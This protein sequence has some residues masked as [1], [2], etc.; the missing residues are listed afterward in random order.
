MLFQRDC[1]SRWLLT[2]ALAV[3]ASLC[4][5]TGTKAQDTVT[6]AFEGRITNSQTGAPIVGASIQ[7]INQA[8]GVPIAKRTDSDGRFYQGLLQPGTYTIRASAP[9]FKT[10]E[11]ERR[12]L[13]T[14][15]NRV[16]P[17]PVTLEPEGTVTTTTTTTT[18]TDPTTTTTTTTTPTTTTTTTTPQGGDQGQQEQ[19]I[20][21][22]I[23]QTDARRGGAFTEREVST[24]PLGAT[25]LVRSFDELALLLPGV[26]LPPLTSG[27]AGPGVGPGVGSPGQFAVNGLRSRA[28]NFTVDGSDN[29]DEDIG[30]RRQGFF[31]LI[32]QPV[33]SIREFQVITLLAPA[34]FGR[35]IGAQVNAISKSGGNEMHGTLYGFFNSSDLNARN[36]FDNTGGQSLV[37]ISVGPRRVSVNCTTALLTDC[38][39]A[40]TL[41]NTGD[42]DSLTLA[43]GGF[44][45]GGPLDVIRG[46]GK[47]RRMFYFVSA[48]GQLMNANKEMSFAVPTVA[49]RGAFNTGLTG[50]SFDPLTGTPV[51]FG[52]EF[53]TTVTGDAIFSFFPFPNNP[54]GIYGQN[55]FTQVI[56]ASA[57][58]KVVSG[59]FDANFD[60]LGRNHNFT[61]RYNLTDDWR[62]IPAVGGALFSR[63]RPRVRTQNFSTFLNTELSGATSTTPVFNQLRLSYGRTRLIFDE[64][65]DTDYLRPTRRRFDDPAQG[66]FL[67]NRPLL[68]NATLPGD[69][70]AT[71]FTFGTGE[72]ETAETDIFGTRIGPIGQLI[73]AGFSPVGVDVFNFPQRRVNNTYQLADTVSMRFGNHSL[74]FGADIRRTELN[75]DLPRNSRPLLTFNGAPR[76][77]A[78]PAPGGGFNF[79]FAANV[80][81]TPRPFISPQD[82]AAAGAPSGVFQSIVRAGRDAALSLRY[83]QLDF[84]VQDEWRIRPNFSLSY[85][86]RYEYNTVPYDTQDRIEST[87]GAALTPNAAVGGLSTFINGRTDIYDPDRN[88]FAPRVGFAWSPDWFGRDKTTVI[89]AGYGLFYDQILGA[90]VSQSRNVFPTFS[91]INF[92]G[93]CCNL[94]GTG[95]DEGFNIFNPLETFYFNGTQFVPIIQ[96]GTVNTLNPQLPFNTFTTTTFNNFPQFFGT[97]FGAT[98]PTRQLEMPMAHHYSATFEQQLSSSMVFSAAYVGTLG[99]NL[100]RFTTPN[101]GPNYLIVPLSYNAFA[102]SFGGGT[103]SGF[104]IDPGSLT[105]AATFVNGR[106][107]ANNIGPISQ[108]ET[109]AESRYDALQLQLRGRFS[110]RMQY[111]VAYTF[112][113]SKDDVSDVF[114]LAGAPALPQNSRTFAG[115]YAD[116]NFDAR[117]RFSYNF[118]IDFPTFSNRGG[119]FRAFFGDYQL[120]STGQ[121]QTGQPFTVNSIYDINLDGNLTDRL[122]S[123]SGIVETGD[124]AQPLQFNGTPSQGFGL[125][126][127]VGR[128]GAVPRNTFRSG[129]ILDL[130]LAV[131]KKFVFSESKN[132]MI[133]MDVFNFID[134]ANYGIPV[135]FLEAPGFGRATDTVTPGRRIQFALKYSF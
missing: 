61:A 102:G 1:P 82:F 58:G 66:Q 70:V 54:T 25:T 118:I 135:R 117:H 63:L 27:T 29:N 127:N 56:P 24:L 48:E 18:T 49:Q 110:T 51:P 88:N 33:E 67:L 36:V 57:Q 124:R 47:P 87:F 126:A 50:V 9:G 120:A 41:L 44:A 3:V 99:R 83:H 21:E 113:H 53:P 42:Q 125:L 112:S 4:L 16:I 96:P 129:N 115:E 128:D 109:T 34:Q 10:A 71:Y 39:Q 93:G 45:F 107:I 7:F 55:T 38:P 30:V 105:P 72:T 114:D 13:A 91:T 86:L 19:S 40:T 32:P 95:L 106:P 68:T 123:T 119:A 46:P 133:R 73:V 2:F 31:S 108:F 79:A 116:S 11:I 122:N 121:F 111:Q 85:G 35:N 78:T 94:L 75:S 64:G 90:V 43:Q 80:P 12:L 103:F 92:G 62:D 74:A 14:Q 17:V 100:L 37:P 84:F 132:F 104:T 76:I 69:P 52:G 26:A 134:R 89:R 97:P 59:K 8:T 60:A 101:L 81:G 28:N 130:N 6:G 20:A 77:V 65:R 15:N 23:N 98:L 5:A 22:T 131:T